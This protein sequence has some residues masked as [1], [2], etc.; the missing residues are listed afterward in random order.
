MKNAEI[1][2]TIESARIANLDVAEKAKGYASQSRSPATLRAYA[3]DWTHFMRWCQE[4]GATPL[5]ATPGNVAGYVADL[6][7]SAKVATIRRRLTTIAQAHLAAG[8]D[9]P[10]IT[11]PVKAVLKGICREKGSAQTK[12]APATTDVVRAM[13]ETLGA[14]DPASV[15]NRAL[16]LIGFAG[17]FRRS[18]VA[19]IERQ[20]VAFVAE[21]VT[22]TL[23]RSKTDQSG[24]GVIVGIPFGSHLET[25][26]VRALTTWL[27][28]SGIE[29]GPIFPAV[30]RH[31]NIKSEALT[32]K[33]IAEIIK[34]VTEDAGLDPEIYSGHSLRAGLVTSAAL[35]DV[36]EWQIMRQSRHKSQA[37]MQKYVRVASIFKKNA[38]GNVGL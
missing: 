25:C 5:P 16:I 8:F 3:S 34:K 21:G 27:Q 36:P 24:K 9:S 37:T 4:H 19:G 22:V 12:K 14:A 1:I 17:A 33:S 11:A 28:E 15:R 30:D 10:T 29:S 7:S 13:V 31:G 38:A 2:A 26:P 35:A 32:G 6:A 20:D 23:R 18:E